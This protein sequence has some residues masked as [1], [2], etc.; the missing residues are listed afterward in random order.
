M[1]PSGGAPVVVECV[2]GP[3]PDGAVRALRAFA[4]GL[5]DAAGRA[6]AGRGGTV[7]GVVRPAAGDAGTPSDALYEGA[8][9]LVRSAAYDVARYGVAV[10]A[11]VRDRGPGPDLLLAALLRVLAAGDATTVSGRVHLLT[12]NGLALLAPPGPVREVVRQPD[13]VRAADLAAALGRPAP[14]PLG[15]VAGRVAVITGGGGGIGRA[16]ADGLADEG[17]AVAVVDLGCDENGTGRDPGPAA[18]VAAGIVRRGGRAVAIC[19]DVSN[20]G[21]CR[22]L[23]GQVERE[24]GPVDVLCHAAGVVRPAL[25]F[26]ST[27]DDWDT[28]AGVHVDGARYLVDAVVGSMREH[29]RGRIV[30]L[31]SRSVTGSPGQSTYAAAK[32]VVAVYGR[33]LADRL[34]PDGIGVAVVLP[35]GRTR[36]SAPARPDARRRRI[37]LLRARQHGITDPAAHRASPEQDP[38]N[39][40]GPVAWLCGEHAGTGDIMATGGRHVELWRLSVAG[41]AVPSDAVRTVDD[42][43]ALA[44]PVTYDHPGSAA[45]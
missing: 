8:A 28:V 29:R 7:V 20:A 32:G 35:R 1:N 11:V 30:L 4:A 13:R 19:A 25:V 10:V 37:E 16:V 36:A 22:A 44:G 39:N 23:V 18:D 27:D 38:E 24:L 31:S 26:E 45:R 17:A 5:R 40:A 6:V 9:G 12:A 33:L 14:P 2:D 41:P 34:A 21:E 3:G 15:V 42:L 43:A